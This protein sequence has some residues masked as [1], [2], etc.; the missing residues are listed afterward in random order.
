[1]SKHNDKRKRGMKY[2][3]MNLRL[4]DVEWQFLQELK[5]SGTSMSEYIRT[6]MKATPRYQNF[7]KILYG[8]QH[9]EEL[10]SKPAENTQP[11]LPTAKW[12]SVTLERDAMREALDD[13]SITIKDVYG[14]R[15][16]DTPKRDGDKYKG[17]KVICPTCFGSGT[18]HDEYCRRC[19]GTGKIVVNDSYGPDEGTKATGNGYGSGSVKEN[20]A[21]KLGGKIDPRYE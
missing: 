7:I 18:V 8:K 6:T 13:D 4:N 17:E 3:V 2:H 10:K 5:E 15:S 21:K 19:R 1:M 9:D 12:N 14:S 20:L 11:S 16:S